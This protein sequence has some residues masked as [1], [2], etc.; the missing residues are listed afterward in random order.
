MIVEVKP[1]SKWK[2]NWRDVENDRPTAAGEALVISSKVFYA[3]LAQTH[4]YMRN[5]GG[6]GGK[7]PQ[8][9][10]LLTDECLTPLYRPGAN[11]ELHLGEPIPWGRHFAEG[12]DIKDFTVQSALWYLCMLS[13]LPDWYSVDYR[14]HSSTS[15]S[16]PEPEPKRKR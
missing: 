4:Y 8:Y 2:P 5:S 15:S 12:Q 3:P 6:R 14:S 9:G 10:A 16:S 1:S 13:S 7:G 11:G